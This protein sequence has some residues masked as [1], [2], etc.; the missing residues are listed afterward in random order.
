MSAQPIACSLILL[1][2]GESFASNADV[3]DLYA[4]ESDQAGSKMLA[5]PRS[6]VAANISCDC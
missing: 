4:A 5:V 1:G 6:W 3:I 2:H